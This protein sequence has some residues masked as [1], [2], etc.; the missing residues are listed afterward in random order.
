[1]LTIFPDSSSHISSEATQ[2]ALY[3][4]LEYLDM[5]ALASPRIQAINHTD[6]FLSRYTV[7]DLQGVRSAEDSPG[8]GVKIRV[9]SWT[10]LISSQWLLELICAIM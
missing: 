2:E 8:I 5:L 9:L 10:G 6:P 7:P 3:D 1:M 4:V